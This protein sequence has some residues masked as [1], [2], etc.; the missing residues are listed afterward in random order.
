[1]SPKVQALLEEYPNFRLFT[2][3]KDYGPITKVLGPLY[4]PEIPRSSALLICDDDVQYLPDCVKIAAAHFAQD[5][6]RVYTF[7]GN[8][9]Q[10]FRGFVVQK[11]LCEKIP[12][13]MPV[14]CRR[15][16]D[17]LLDLHFKDR[18]TPIAYHTNKSW[19]CSIDGSDW[20]DHHTNKKTALRNDNRPPMV[21]QCRRDFYKTEKSASNALAPP[22]IDHG[23]TTSSKD[24]TTNE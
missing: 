10:G 1:V 2:T 24:Y 23:N 7:C 11:Q 20:G 3:L 17:D 8:G 14:S 6:T 12:D 4:N 16:D 21:A 19:L 15:I 13:N 5:A 9:V 18:A 22:G